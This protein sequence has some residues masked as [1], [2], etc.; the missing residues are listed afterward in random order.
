MRKKNLLLITLLA[1]FAGIFALSC[2]DRSQ[3]KLFTIAL[4]GQFSTLDPIGALT[5]DGSSER[6]RTLMYNSLVKKD[7][8]FEYVGDLASKFELSEDGLK[9]TFT[10]RDN[11]KFHND[12][13]LSSAD[14]KYTLEKLLA[15][16]GGKGA[17]FYET[18]DKKKTPII[19]LIDAPDEKTI[20]IGIA[21]PELKNQLIPNL[22]PVSIIPKDAPVGKDSNADKNPP[23]GTGAYKF[24]SFDQAQ[25]IVQLEGFDDAWEGAPNIKEIQVKVLADANA[26]Q[27]ELLSGGVDLAPTAVN[28]EADTIEN[29]KTDSRL[30]VVTTKG[31]N[32][33]YLW[34]NTEADPVKNKKVRQA[35]AYAVNRERIIK[36]ILDGQATIAYSILPEQSWAY[37]KGTEYSFDPEKAKSLLDEAGYKD[38]NGDGVREMPKIIF[39]VSSG[40]KVVLQYAQ[41]IQ[42]NIKDVGVPI[43]I[44]S[45]EFRTMQEQVQMGQFIMM[46]GRWLGGNQDPLFLKDLYAS[47]EIPNKDRASRNRGRYNNPEVDKLI[48]QAL[49]EP[50]REKAKKDYQQVQKIVSDDAPMIPL[51]YP[52]NIVVAAANVENIKINASGDWY[53]VKDLKLK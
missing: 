52:D 14:V 33:Q 31:S 9:Y 10:L 21:R 49:V 28:L 27:A 19:T 11:V 7:D 23:P 41:L 47:T 48:Q 16:N 43:D 25:N 12:K 45:L 20:V 5:V 36:D 13:V 6:I 42:N 38:T 30:N 35:I 24:K 53:F 29:M 37:E 39:K 34:F 1:I 2:R 4:D 15:S 3:N 18:I 51:W 50:D 22:V 8:K 40:N 46:T 17:A 26:L 32:I 44:E